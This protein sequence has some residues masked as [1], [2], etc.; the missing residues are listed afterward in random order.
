MSAVICMLLLFSI[1]VYMEASLPHGAR[2]VP[3][4]VCVADDPGQASRRNSRSVVTDVNSVLTK[5]RIEAK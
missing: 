4:T 3:W 1:S 5:W 2:S